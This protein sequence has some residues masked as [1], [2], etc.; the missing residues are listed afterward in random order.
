MVGQ[1]IMDHPR[2]NF[3]SGPTE[4]ETQTGKDESWGSMLES[5]FPFRLN[6]LEIEDGEIHFQNEHSIPPVDIAL[7]KLSVTATN[8]TNSREIKNELPAGI[9]PGAPPS[10][11]AGST[12]KSSLTRWT[13]RR[14]IN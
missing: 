9:T 13:K 7:K 10:A 14:P 8:L 6:R 5:L 2:L 11:E 12:F 3:V 1:V 4:A